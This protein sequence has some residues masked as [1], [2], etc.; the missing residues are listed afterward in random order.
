MRPAIDQL[1]CHDQRTLDG[2][3]Q[4]DFDDHGVGGQMDFFHLRAGKRSS[5]GCDEPGDELPLDVA[6]DRDFDVVQ[7]LAMLADRAGIAA[8]RN[9]FALGAAELG[10]TLGNRAGVQ[11]R[12]EQP[13]QRLAVRPDEHGIERLGRLAANSRQFSFSSQMR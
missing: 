1:E 7:R 4:R 10:E 11:A 9:R 6:A 13:R 2:A 8:G 3:G 12:P 5:R